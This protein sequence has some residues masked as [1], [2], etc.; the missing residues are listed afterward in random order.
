MLPI[1]RPA[2]F[3]AFCD[4][5]TGPMPMID[6]LQPADAMLTILASGLRPSA[7]AL[8]ADMINV[9]DAPSEIAELLPA[10]TLPL[11]LTAG[12]SLPRSARLASGRP[13]SSK[14]PSR[15]RKSVG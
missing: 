12:L 4:A 7:L 6:G 9:H 10:V 8:S 3:S 11:G 13:P 15:K 1:S 14:S 5:G 2:R